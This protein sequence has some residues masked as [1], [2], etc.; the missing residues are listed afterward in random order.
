MTY[1]EE[2]K[3]NIP[4]PAKPLQ[5][6]AQSTAKG[7]TGAAQS[8]VKGVTSLPNTIKDKALAPVWNFLKNIW[9]KFKYFVSLACCLCIMSCCLSLGVPQMAWKAVAQSAA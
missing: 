3:I 8:T 1:R 5:K 4:N 2:F 9:E 7:V 6:A